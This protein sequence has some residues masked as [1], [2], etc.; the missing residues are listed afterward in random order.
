M[1]QPISNLSLNSKVKFGKYQGKQIIWKIADKNHSGYPS[2]SVTL[3][4]DDI[5]CL[6]A[7]DAKEPTNNVDTRK[8]YGN[9][10]YSYSNIR[11]WLN[12]SGYPWYT[13]Q[14]SADTPPNGAG[15]DANPYDVESGFLTEFLNDE[16]NAILDTTLLSVMSIS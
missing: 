6:K 14:H 8:A 11:Q 2:N 12:K 10:R 9:N 13:S 16:L 4:S 3:V 5:I 1:A 7:F 15:V